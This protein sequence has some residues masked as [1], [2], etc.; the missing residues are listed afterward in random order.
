MSRVVVVF[1]GNAFASP[2]GRLTMAG[3]LQFAHDALRQVE[4]LLDEGVELL[5]SHGNGPQVG[6]ILTRVE[7]ALG[8]AYSIPLEVCVAESEGE[9]GYVLQQSLYNVLQELGRSRS[10]VGLL[11]QVVVDENDDA[12]QNPTKPIGPFYEQADAE[13]LR[14]KGFQVIEDAGRGFRRV[15]PSPQPR[16]IV[17]LDVIRKLLA[18]GV[19]VIAAGGGGIPVVQRNGRLHGLE[20][21]IDKDLTAALMA[22][23]LDAELLVILT[24]VPCAYRHFNTP[25]QEA[26]G[27]VGVDR[28]R[29]L[30]GEGHFAPG[31]MKPKMEAAI[32]FVTKPG[33]RAMICDPPSLARALRG[34]A[35]TLIEPT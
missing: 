20:A 18:L 2:E 6:H 14:Q 32:Q 10:I 27:R 16:A 3:Q 15:V 5:I 30:L 25:K 34:A 26:I 21:V 1:G 8:K 11:T 19:I 17:E 29:T 23:Q 9:L 4:S 31:S 33:R 35:G 13:S 24:G 22:D 7:E 12:F 28:A